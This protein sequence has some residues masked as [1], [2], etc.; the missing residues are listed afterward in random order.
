MYRYGYG[1]IKTSLQFQ[2][3]YHMKGKKLVRLPFCQN[4]TDLIISF[5]SLRYCDF[6]ENFQFLCHVIFVG[7]CNYNIEFI[8]EIHNRDA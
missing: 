2:F 8:V 7:Q 5:S 3:L 6:C 4:L 1:N